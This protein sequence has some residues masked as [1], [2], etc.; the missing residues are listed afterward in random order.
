MCLNTGDRK[1]ESVSAA[2]LP[3]KKPKLAHSSSVVSGS[4]VRS[5]SIATQENVDAWEAYAL[6]FDPA[7]FMTVISEALSLND[8]EKVVSWLYL[9]KLINFIAT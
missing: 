1:R 6:D 3:A 2:I 4:V 7:D 5:T 9:N 8:Q